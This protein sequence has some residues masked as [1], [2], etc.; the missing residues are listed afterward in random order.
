MKSAF[1]RVSPV[2]K[3]K[4]KK[5]LR[6]FFWF[7]LILVVLYIGLGLLSHL[8]SLVIDDIKVV[9]AEVLDKDELREKVLDYLSGNSALLYAKGNIF[10]FSK[11]KLEDFVY[12]EF[13]R[14]YQVLDIERQ[15]Q[16]LLIEIE[17]RTSAYLWC[18]RNAPV[19][20]DRFSDK[21]CYFIDQKGFIFDKAPFFTDGVYLSF[22]GGV[23]D[24]DPIG[25]T[26]QT[27][28]SMEAI[29]DFVTAIEDAGIK[30]HSLVLNEDGQHF[31]LLD[32]ITNTGDFSKII[33]NED[34]KISD[35]SAK[36]AVA[37][38]GEDF[39]SDFELS[40]E[41]LEYIDTR[42]K[43]RVFYKFQNN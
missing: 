20:Q 3:E 19:Y 30:T 18:G 25:Q 12:K 35:I 16:T 11:N 34:E 37:L 13:P 4:S 23:S 27:K 36:T 33:F 32:I 41:Y 6:G 2:K 7:I 22:Y 8:K 15:K 21:D 1:S 43:N 42:F 9:G 17:E 39:L 14:V 5:K 24:K 10:L 31:I 29:K 28:N 38:E 40:K 26:L